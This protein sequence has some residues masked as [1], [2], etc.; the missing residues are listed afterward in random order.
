[1]YVLRKLVWIGDGHSPMRK[2]SLYSLLRNL[3]CVL[4]TALVC[5]RLHVVCHVVQLLCL[6]LHVVCYLHRVSFACSA[7]E[8]TQAGR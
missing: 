5:C 4:D 3:P 7:V 6:A 8:L 2:I 1:V